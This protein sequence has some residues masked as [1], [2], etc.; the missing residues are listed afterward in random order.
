MVDNKKDKNMEKMQKVDKFNF[1]KSIKEKEKKV[2][3]YYKRISN[4][5]ESQLTVIK[6]K[7]R[8]KK[9][10]KSSDSK[11]GNGLGGVDNDEAKTEE[12]YKQDKKEKAREKDK[13]EKK[14]K[15]TIVMMD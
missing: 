9:N 6:V 13:E 5:E 2:L 1:N 8:T 4:K 7:K 14:T 10:I 3:D 15:K 12:E 11:S